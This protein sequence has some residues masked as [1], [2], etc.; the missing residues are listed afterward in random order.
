MS[1]TA[2]GWLLVSVFMAAGVLLWIVARPMARL[3]VWWQ[4]LLA[5]APGLRWSSKFTY[6]EGTQVLMVRLLAVFFVVFA[7]LGAVLVVAL[8]CAQSAPQ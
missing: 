2:V 5:R 8:P 7:I 1:P 4:S 6:D 3:S